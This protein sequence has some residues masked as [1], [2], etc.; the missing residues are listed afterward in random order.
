MQ[1]ICKAWGIYCTTMIVFQVPR[2]LNRTAAIIPPAKRQRQRALKSSSKDRRLRRIRLKE[3]SNKRRFLINSRRAP[4]LALPPRSRTRRPPL[5]RMTASWSDSRVISAGRLPRNWR[6]RP[7]GATSTDS[8]E[9][10]YIHWHSTNDSNRRKWK[11]SYSNSSSSLQLISHL[12]PPSVRVRWEN[13]SIE[14]LT[15]SD[16]L[17]PRC[18]R[19]KN[20]FIHFIFCT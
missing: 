12:R 8:P 7:K 13:R 4:S 3:S 11:Y 9:V 14:K 20:I 1:L 17:S 18:D 19:Y 6:R 15:P 5:M 10:K 16:K 2:I